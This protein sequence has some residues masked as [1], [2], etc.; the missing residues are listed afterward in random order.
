MGTTKQQVVLHVIIQIHLA[1]CAGSLLPSSVGAFA[2][3]NTAAL[4]VPCL[5]N[6]ASALLRLKRSFATTNS[7]LI[8]FRSWRVG[9]DCCRWLGV[10][11]GDSDGRVTSL[12]LGNRGLESEG[13][14]PVIF[15][16]ASLRYLNL[17]YN[18]FNNSQL[19]SAGFERLVNLTHLNL[20]TSS[21]SGQVPAGINRL[22]NLV[23]LDLSTSFKLG[24]GA[25][26]FSGDLPSSIG[27]FKSLRGLEISGNGI[28]G[29]IPSWVANLTYLTN[30]QFHD[31]GL[32]SSI[33]TF[34]GHLRHLQQLFLCNCGFSGHIPSHIS[35]LTQLQMLM[36]SSNNLVGTV[37]LT[38]FKNLGRLIT[39]DLS[40]NN[41]VVL[42]GKY[43]SSLTS[44]PEFRHLGLAGCNM[45]K[46]P[47]FLKYQDEILVLDLSYNK[48]HGA[49]PGWAWELWDGIY[50]LTLAF[51]E[52]TSVGYSPF[53]PI[54][55]ITVLDL[56]NN[57]L[58]GPIPVPQGSAEVLA[59][60]NN[61]FSYIPSQL[62]S[63]L[64]DA[65]LFHAYNN[66]LSGNLSESFCGGP[67]ILLLDLSENNFSGSI[68][69]CLMENVNGM[70]S[71]K[72]RKNQLHGEIPDS[73]VA[74]C[75]F[76]ALD[77]SSN[78]I[79][80]QVP[81]SLLACKNL[82]IFNVGNN[83]ISDCFP[84]WMSEL[85][86][87]Q[88]LILK[89]NKF[90]GQVAQQI[91]EVDL[92]SNNFLGSLPKDQWFK[93]L[94]SM[95]FSDPNLSSSINHE[96]PGVAITYHYSTAI[97]YKGHEDTNFAKI[98]TA[99]VFIDFSNNAFNG[100]IP[101]AIGQL[102]LLHGL[103]ISHNFLTGPIPSQLAYLKELE[104][105]DLSFNEL[106]GNIPQELAS[107]DFL[108]MLNL[109]YNRLVG[110][111]PVSPHFLT[112]TSSF[113]GN[114]GL[115]GP[116]LPKA[117]N[118][119]TVPNLVSSKKKSTDIILFLFVGLGFGVGFAIAIAVA[120]GIPVRK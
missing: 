32:S 71:L 110:S 114:D 47:N 24:L 82:E 99:L 61:L 78:H 42:D 115:C 72:L 113:Q 38:F 56:A 102:G 95:I 68:P 103:N 74:G 15:Y 43:N 90:F 44:F 33:P 119:K 53:L 118:N 26:G 101:T 55:D 40:Y 51:N 3:N 8:A 31:C 49:I 73:T 65:G 11:C 87:L 52:F 76:E 111:I 2:S 22:T 79:K 75:S 30:L 34:I 41:L 60:S 4:S 117:C 50:F 84:C 6:Q 59:Y 19:P 88:V 80:G 20:S 81:R 7:S 69:S 13:L 66:K 100:S 70:Q 92:S 94:R 1:L 63:H 29:S 86:R 36:F 16:L 83:E 97:T 18:D 5:P 27:N 58:E 91:Q 62:S 107:L 10:H 9:T 96:V 46:F 98:L 116:P 45:M 25:S 104:A 67:N 48:I 12:D 21:F 39:L 105:L 112:F 57:L 14:D 85:L 23:S 89:S 37:D 17:A 106:S 108:S 54:Q 109:S 77:F 120:W 93:N 64:S 35:N 28:V